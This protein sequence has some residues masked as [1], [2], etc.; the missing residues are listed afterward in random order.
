MVWLQMSCDE[1]MFDPFGV[2]VRAC[3]DTHYVGS[4]SSVVSS[5]GSERLMSCLV[6]RALL[7]VVGLALKAKLD[8]C[9]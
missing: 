7:K 3:R 8:K 4:G 1:K 9:G 2:T 6:G 5:K